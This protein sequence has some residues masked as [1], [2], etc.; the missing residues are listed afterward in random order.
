MEESNQWTLEALEKVA[1]KATKV[2]KA[3]KATKAKKAGKDLTQKEKETEEKVTQRT[4]ESKTKENHPKRVVGKARTV[5]AHGDQANQDG[6][7]ILKITAKDQQETA[8]F[9]IKVGTKPKIVGKDGSSPWTLA[10][11]IKAHKVKTSSGRANS[12]G[13]EEVRHQLKKL[14]RR[15]EHITTRH[16]SSTSCLEVNHRALR[17]TAIKA[18][19][20]YH[21][22]AQ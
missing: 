8:T 11:L 18:H 21:Q 12:N 4:K 10:T 22:R 15:Q 19:K 6:K 13:K 1:Q 17:S 20:A 3:Q 2:K 5:M 14:H 7:T 9:A 16:G